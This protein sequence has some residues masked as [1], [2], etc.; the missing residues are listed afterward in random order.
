MRRVSGSWRRG[1]I[2]L[3]MRVFV[4]LPDEVISRVS[5]GYEMG[6]QMRGGASVS[7]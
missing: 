1:D 4:P 7:S 2:S 5:G 6:E 3:N